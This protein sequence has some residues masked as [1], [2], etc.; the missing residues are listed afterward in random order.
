M[1]RTLLGACG[2]TLL[3]LLAAPQAEARGGHGGHGSCGSHS[4]V[5]VGGRGVILYTGRFVQPGFLHDPKVA[6]RS[7]GDNRFLNHAYV[8]F[9]WGGFWPGYGDWPTGYTY[10][11]LQQV[12][13]PPQPP[14]VIV[15]RT[16]GNRRMATA[17]AQPDI[18]YVKGCYAIPNGYHCDTP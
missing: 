18:S 4:G 13:T 7:V 11:P 2:A 14:Q 9:P 6:R 8:G 3:S 15:I 1:H 10:Q 16:D 12:P 5:H 17:D